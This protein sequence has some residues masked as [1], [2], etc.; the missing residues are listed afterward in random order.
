MGLDRCIRLEKPD[1]SMAFDWSANYRAHIF[2]RECNELS[3]C[4]APGPVAFYRACNL[5]FLDQ[6]VDSSV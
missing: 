4:D 6:A 1:L 2:P 5:T 3:P